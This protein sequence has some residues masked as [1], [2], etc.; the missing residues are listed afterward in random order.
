MSLSEGYKGE[1][2]EFKRGLRM[3]L[4]FDLFERVR[5]EIYE[6]FSFQQGIEPKA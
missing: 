2:T 4:I 3:I 1:H 5:R 6:S